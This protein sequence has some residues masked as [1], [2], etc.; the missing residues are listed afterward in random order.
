MNSPDL[1]KPIEAHTVPDGKQLNK[2]LNQCLHMMQR[3]LK[4]EIPLCIMHSISYTEL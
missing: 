3:L 1:F 2:T 4:S